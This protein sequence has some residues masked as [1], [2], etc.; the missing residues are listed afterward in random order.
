MIHRFVLRLLSVESVKDAIQHFRITA[1]PGRLPHPI[2]QQLYRYTL[3]RDGVITGEL[4]RSGSLREAGALGARS[5]DEVVDA[6]EI[7]LELLELDLDDPKAILA[8][9]NRFGVLGVSYDNYA[10]VR[11][12]P[13]F[14]DS[15]RPALETAWPHRRD[16]SG[17]A[18]L[19]R[20]TMLVETLA[21][22]R[23]GAF[24]LRDLTSAREAVE[25]PRAP[26]SP[27]PTWESVPSGFHA[28]PIWIDLDNGHQAG[29]AESFL[30]TMMNSA[31]EVFHPQLFSAALQARSP[32][33]AL[34]GRPIYAI[35]CL[36]LYNH[37]VDRAHYRRCANDTCERIFVRQIGR[38]EQGQHRSFGIKY[39]SNSCARAQAQRE[40]RRRA[41]RS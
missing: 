11:H 17:A 1:W 15:V 10:L 26:G 4:R 14:E 28:M 41:R 2:V 34:S 39:C 37:I 24:C 38:A 6:G 16:A 20:G 18:R 31:L 36:E 33:E 12:L 8:F 29:E 30:I 7:Y 21:E 19:N 5:R 40:Y 22:F 35:C 3:G 23:L 27:P 25:T 9:A 32:R 13:G